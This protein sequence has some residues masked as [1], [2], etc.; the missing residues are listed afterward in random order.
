MEKTLTKK[1]ESRERDIFLTGEYI[2]HFKPDDKRNPFSKIYRQKKQDTIDIINKS[3]NSKTILDVGGGMGRLSIALAQSEQ[4]EIVLTDIS[5]DML[6]LVLKHA[7]S[8]NNIV[9]VKADAHQLPFPDSSFDIVVGLDLL[10][11]LE[12]PEM[13]LHEFYRVLTNQGILILDSTNSNPSWALFYPRYIGKNPLNW[14]KILKFKGNLPGW[15]T[16][17]KHYTRKNFF[18]LLHKMGFKVIQNLN[19]GPMICPKW[20]LAVSRKRN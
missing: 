6:K 10:C 5:I 11:H 20:H 16:I 8:S 1:K 7:D 9:V 18:S 3:D 13:A 17:V 12:K 15:E 4:N 2:Q 14:F 19:Y